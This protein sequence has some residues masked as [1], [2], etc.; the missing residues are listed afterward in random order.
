CAVKLSWACVPSPPPS[1]FRQLGGVMNGLA[2]PRIGA[3]AA[4][5]TCHRS[6]DVLVGGIGGAGE[7]GRG[8]H[9]LPRLAVAALR[10]GMFD[11][12]PL[13]GVTG[14]SRQ[15]FDG[16]DLPADGAFGGRY[17][18]AHRLS[19]H[20]DGTDAALGDA[21]AELRAGEAQVFAKHPQQRR[22]RIDVELV[23]CAVYRQCQRH[24]LALAYLLLRCDHRNM[25]IKSPATG[26]TTIHIRSSSRNVPP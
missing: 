7:Q 3:A 10:N 15:A 8:G 20:V 25:P 16:S 21:A 18:G 13:H 6:V 9:D 14:V 22:L 11:P 17:A 24:W 19:I 12:C 4:Q 2:Y 26:K 5:V 1:R 23:S